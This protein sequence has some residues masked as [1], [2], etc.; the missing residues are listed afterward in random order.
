[1]RKKFYPFLMLGTCLILGSCRNKDGMGNAPSYPVMT[2]GTDSVTIDEYY[3]AS[4]QGQQD[5][6]IY[7]QV[8][9][10]IT[11]IHIVEGERVRKGEVLFTIDQVP[12][13]AALRTATANVHAAEAQVATARLDYESKQ[14]LFS[15]NVVAEYDVTA[16]ANQLAASEAALEQARA[17]ELAASNDLSYTEVRSPADGTVG[18]LP[19]RA[20]SLVSPSM[21]QPLTTLSDDA[22]MYVYFSMGENQ[23]RHLMRKYGSPD[24]VIGRMPPIRLQLNDGSI[25]GREGRI[26][27][28]S[29]VLNRQT[30]TVS[31]RSVFPNEDR[32]LLSGGIGNVVIAHGEQD[33]VVIPQNAT[34]E[35]QDKVF[36][37]KV[38][39]GRV[40]VS[41]LAVE[42]LHDGKEYIVRK[43]L[44]PGDVI[45]TEGVGMLH[46][47]MEI[48]P[49]TGA[50]T[51]ETTDNRGRAGL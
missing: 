12:Y 41:E 36:S 50:A 24:K 30:G 1:M 26:E 49:R 45:V 9:G 35:I 46:D 33:V 34:Y 32:M 22:C 6:E 39:D 20:G 5:I 43:G 21:A 47:G 48:T 37:Y 3:S 40:A 18:T 27:T 29:G 23:L 19:F 16:A 42:R 25:Y 7:P 17:Q 28:I 11:R 8:S 13:I 2:V 38:V 31:V 4:I 10:T 44:S 15:E 51:G 14:A